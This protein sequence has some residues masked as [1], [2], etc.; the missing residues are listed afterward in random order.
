MAEPGFTGSIPVTSTIYQMNY[1]K[2][3][4]PTLLGKLKDNTKFKMSDG[5]TVCHFLGGKCYV[6]GTEN[7][8]AENMLYQCYPLNFDKSFIRSYCRKFHNGRKER[9]QSRRDKRNRAY[10]MRPHGNSTCPYC[11]GTMSWCSCC[12]VYSSDCCVDY[13]TCQCS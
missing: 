1:K 13:G 4:I 7:R 11:G 10:D 9:A 6:S 8:L 2:L 12:K 3:K 5:I